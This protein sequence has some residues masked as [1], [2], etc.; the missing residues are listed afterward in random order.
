MAGSK[1]K[2]DIRRNK[3]LKQLRAEGRVSVSQLAQELGTTCVTIRNDLFALEQDGYLVRVQGGAVL[4]SSVSGKAELADSHISEYEDKRAIADAI[5]SQIS[6]GDTLFLNSG[7][8]TLCVAEALRSRKDLNIV[9]NSLE[10]ATRLG[11]VPSVRVVL[12]GGEINAQ[13]GFTYGGDTQEQLGRYQ[14]DW[15]ILSVEGISASNGITTH[16]A[17]EALVDRLMMGGAKRVI[18][19]ADHTKLGRVG[20]ARVCQCSDRFLLVTDARADDAAV[21]LLREQGMQVIKA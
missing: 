5:V 21:A 18:L 19:A 6:N 16:H 17:E 11:G 12:L 10:V 2:I 1:L 4:L 9:T 15:V 7:T 13:Y 20:F 8:T 14:A 3:I